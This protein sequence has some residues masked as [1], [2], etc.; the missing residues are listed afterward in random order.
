MKRLEFGIAMRIATE[1]LSYRSLIEEIESDLVRCREAQ[2]TE[3]LR[4]LF[5]SFH[6]QVRHHF[7][8][9]ERGGLF[10]VYQEHG[11]AFRQ[12][13]EGMRAQHRDFTARMRGIRESVSTLDRPAGPAFERCARELRALFAD[14]REHERAEDALLEHFVERDIR[15]QD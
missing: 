3:N 2:S 1:H 7:A 14:L 11:F 12:H 9:E 13:A 10:D 4:R 8:L 5:E 6:T 15:H